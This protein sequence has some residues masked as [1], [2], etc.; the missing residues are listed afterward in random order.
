MLFRELPVG[1]GSDSVQALPL[2]DGVQRSARNPWCGPKCSLTKSIYMSCLAVPCLNCSIGNLA[3]TQELN[4]EFPALGALILTA[5]PPDVPEQ[6]NEL[7][8]H[9]LLVC[10]T[11]SHHSLYYN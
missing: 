2:W 7:L 1:V 9:S 8:F 5:G 3:P 6:L 4:L 11:Y 10:L